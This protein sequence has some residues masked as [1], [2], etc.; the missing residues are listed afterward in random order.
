[1]GDNA[2]STGDLFEIFETL[3]IMSDEFSYFVDEFNPETTDPMHYEWAS[4]ELRRLIKKHWDKV[5]K[6]PDDI[7][8]AKEEWVKTKAVWDSE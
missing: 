1:M 6:L 5:P 2:Q 8:K 3:K 7:D 4:R